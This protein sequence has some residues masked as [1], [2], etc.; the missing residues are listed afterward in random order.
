[1]AGSV[2]VDSDT[3]MSDIN[4]TPLVDVML[5]LL[6]IFLITVPAIVQNVK[7]KLPDVRYDP[8]TTKPENVSLSVRLEDTGKCGIYWGQTPMTHQELYDR[9]HTKMDADIKRLQAEGPID[10]EKIPEV[11]I[12]A[13]V[14][15]PYR[16]VGAAIYTM[17]SAGF[18]KVGFIS[19]PEPTGGPAS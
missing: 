13:D 2:G 12:R 17:Q 11:H 4:T 10:P 18:I 16:C 1:M 3:P 6:I 19:Q 7:L 14:N 5:V 8:T 15:T 9:A